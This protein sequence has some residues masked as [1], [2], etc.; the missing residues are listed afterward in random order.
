[1]SIIGCFRTNIGRFH[2]NIDRF[3]QHRPLST[4]GIGRFRPYSKTF[5][6]SLEILGF[7]ILIE[8]NKRCQIW[9]LEFYF[10]R[11]FVTILLSGFFFTKVRIFFTKSGFFFTKVIIRNPD[12]IVRIFVYALFKSRVVTHNYDSLEKCALQ[13]CVPKILGQKVL[14]NCSK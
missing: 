6:I 9:G 3:K 14:T 4:F 11:I 5:L 12:K 10:V 2:A 7:E 13:K 8:L 1:M